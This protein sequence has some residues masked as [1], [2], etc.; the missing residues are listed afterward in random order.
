MRGPHRL[1]VRQREAVAGGHRQPLG[2]ERGRRAVAGGRGDRDERVEH[3]ADAFGVEE[4]ARGHELQ[5]G[6]IVR[7]R[8]VGQGDQPRDARLT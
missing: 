3:H 6:A 5:R 2:Q 8:Q 7:V 4:A 1:D